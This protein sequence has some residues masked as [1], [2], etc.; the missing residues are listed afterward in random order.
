INSGT[1]ALFD[2]SAGGDFGGGK[3][4]SAGAQ[5]KS[6]TYEDSVAS[7]AKAHTYLNGGMVFARVSGD[8]FN[9]PENAA[10]QPGDRHWLVSMWLKIA[11]YGAGTA[12]SSNNQVFSFSTSNVN[13]LA[14]SMFG[15]APITVESA[16]PSAI[17]IYARGRQYV[18]T[19]ALAK[20]FDGQLHQ[21]AVECL[22]SDD[23]TQQRVIV[24][25]DQLN[26]FD[27]GWT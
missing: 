26:V 18:I 3:N 7:F 23:G 8:T 27:S 22:V 6:L 9:L 16:S 20:L 13:L 19:A 14:G 4:I 11:N 15:L 10:P 21:L 2:M 25:L 24:Y 17:T 1:T 12:N 5:I